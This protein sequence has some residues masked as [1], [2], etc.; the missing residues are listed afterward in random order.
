MTENL[1]ETPAVPTRSTYAVVALVMGL[2]AFVFLAASNGPI[3]SLV[4]LG[5]VGFGILG[6]REINRGKATGRALGIVGLITGIFGFLGGLGSLPSSTT[7]PVTAAATY[8]GG[9]TIVAPNY[10]PARTPVQPANPTVISATRMG[11][12]FESNQVA[13]EKKWGGQFV[14]FTSTVTNI[15]SSGVSFG[16]VTSQ[17][18]FTQISCRVKDESSVL[19]LAKG[20]P[21]TVRGIVDGDQLLGVIGL[22]ECEIVSK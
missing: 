4:G 17:F 6:L 19:S 16:K 21:A 9:S 8:Q 10:Q 1:S 13:A 12:D 11:D 20:K 14:Q 2:F 7:S 18:S 3:S 22:N 15:N 5:A